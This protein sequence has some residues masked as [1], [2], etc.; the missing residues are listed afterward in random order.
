MVVATNEIVVF[1]EVTVTM[2]EFKA[3]NEKLVFVYGDEEGAKQARSHIAKLRKVK[4]KISDVHKEA[5]AE[6]LAFGRRLD[7]KKRELTGEVEEM[8]AV[9]K[10]PLDVIADKK[11]A[12]I[13]TE[14]ARLEAEELKRQAEL[15]ARETAVREAEQK[16]ATE[17]AEAERIEREKQ[18]AEEAAERAKAEAEAK[19]KA[20]ADAKELAERHRKEA[21]EAAEQKRVAN[22]KHRLEIENAIHFALTETGQVDNAGASAVL[23]AIKENKIPYLSIDY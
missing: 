2:A 21:K 16:L 12:E 23:E 18:I 15:E 19:A 13:D 11:Q 5:K 9:H 10:D 14:K 17:K 7:E 8:I 6:S 22:K 20:E 3:E 4:T 1:D